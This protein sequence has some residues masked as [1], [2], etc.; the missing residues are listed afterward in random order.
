MSS[1]SE[2]FNKLRSELKELQ[3][4]TIQFE[5]DLQQHERVLETISNLPDDRKCFRLIGEVL[6]QMTIGDA[7]PALEQ[8]K[9]SLKELINTFNPKIKAKEEELLAFQKEHNIQIRPLNEIPG[10]NK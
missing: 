1:L 9:A 3:N 2:Q 10:L 7:K 8:Q 5:L 4:K 6:V